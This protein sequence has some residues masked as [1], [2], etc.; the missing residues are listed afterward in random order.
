MR[1]GSENH[2]IYTSTAGEV[3]YSII[4]HEQNLETRQ[5]NGG[6]VNTN[7]FINSVEKEQLHSSSVHAHSQVRPA[8]MRVSKK[9]HYISR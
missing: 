1:R 8:S 7:V 6:Q 3:K 2:V 5:M 9:S 4:K